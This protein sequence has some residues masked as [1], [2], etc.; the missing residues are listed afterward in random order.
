MRALDRNHGRCRRRVAQAQLA[1]V[2]QLHD[3]DW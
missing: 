2:A 1:R 3:A